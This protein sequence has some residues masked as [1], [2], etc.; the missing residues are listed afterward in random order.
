[1]GES[2][3]ARIASPESTSAFQPKRRSCAASSSSQGSWYG[4]IATLISPLGAQ[5]Q[6]IP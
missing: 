2:T 1:V 6:S 5:P 3:C 4:A